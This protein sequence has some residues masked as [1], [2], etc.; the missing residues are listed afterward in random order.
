MC[1]VVVLHHFY[2]LHLSQ[3]VE[4]RDLTALP[5]QLRK[6]WYLDQW[7]FCSLPLRGT[8]VCLLPNVSFSYSRFDE[9]ERAYLRGCCDLFP[10][11]LCCSGPEDVC[12]TSRIYQQEYPL[13]YDCS[14]MFNWKRWIDIR[15]D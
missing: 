9:L 13:V 10:G 12:W 11:L 1:Y 4:E 8:I 15:I 6:G 14:R 7:H 2:L 3:E 5:L